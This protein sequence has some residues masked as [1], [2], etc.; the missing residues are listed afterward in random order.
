MFLGLVVEE[1]SWVCIKRMSRLVVG[2]YVFVVVSCNVFVC[3][4]DGVIVQIC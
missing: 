3:I 4:S 1:R 2:C